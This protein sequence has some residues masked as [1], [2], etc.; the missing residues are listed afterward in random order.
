MRNEM[1]KGFRKNQQIKENNLL[2]I[3]LGKI[4]AYIEVIISSKKIAMIVKGKVTK[5]SASNA[6]AKL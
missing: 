3:F 1:L 6:Q 5:H 2:V 4:H